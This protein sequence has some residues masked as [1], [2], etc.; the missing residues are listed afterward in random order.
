M[1]GLLRL[2]QMLSGSVPGGLGLLLGLLAFW[3]FLVFVML[4]GTGIFRRR[5]PGPTLLVGCL[6]LGFLYFVAHRRLT[7]PPPPRTILLWPLETSDPRLGCA[8]A[9]VE[10]EHLLQAGRPMK[11]RRHG[12][13]R[14]L[15]QD[16]SR[17]AD[18]LRASGATE[19]VGGRLRPQGLHLEYLRLEYGVVTLEASEQL[20]LDPGRDDLRHL[21]QVYHN[22][23]SRVAGL[24]GLAPPER[25]LDVT[26]L[27]LY[28]MVADSAAQ[29]LLIDREF[30]DYRDRLQAAD[31]QLAVARERYTEPLRQTLNEGLAD[32]GRASAE[33]FLFAATWFAWTGDWDRVIQA[34]DNTLSLEPRHP[35]AWW[36]ISRLNREG[37]AHFGLQESWQALEKSL[38]A[39]PGYWPALREYSQWLLDMRRAA[40]AREYL[41]RALVLCPDHPELLLQAVSADRSVMNYGSG[42]ERLARVEELL[43]GDVRP[44][45]E[46]GQLHYITG[47]DS[48]AVLAF[49][50][51]VKMGCTPD[52]LHYLGMSHM[53]MR[54][55]QKARWYFERR[56]DHE[57]S[58]AELDRS[59]RQLRRLD[60]LE[61]QARKQQETRP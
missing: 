37:L 39:Q 21:L 19:L 30:S 25:I 1:S 22:F 47:R 60:Q 36:I 23:C 58:V 32:P 28:G 5:R 49:E 29:Q 56:L 10:E 8:L 2:W 54:H 12:V 13:V 18:V 41:E 16:S 40:K 4:P 45:Y 9:S 27:P 42:L 55:L 38:E 34:L 26:T 53:Q 59:R 3:I 11:I 46:R 15:Q 51:A 20:P 44:V 24:A 57:G 14:G 31:Y 52:A 61:E 50:E 17:L 48:L 35:R 33:L 7:P 6:L 43:P